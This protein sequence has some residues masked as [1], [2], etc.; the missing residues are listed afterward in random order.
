MHPSFQK[1][2]FLFYCCLR[3]NWFIKLSS[4]MLQCY[5][6]NHQETGCDIK[7]RLYWAYCLLRKKK[8]S[9][10]CTL[11]TNKSRSSVTV[12]WNTIH[13]TLAIVKSLSLFKTF[14]INYESGKGGCFYCCTIL[15]S[16]I[17]SYN[18]L[19]LLWHLALNVQSV[20]NE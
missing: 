15:Y 6:L 5:L 11:R 13:L 8:L 9:C 10:S 3:R 4:Q 14:H 16:S 17:N 7:S 18:V 12:A 1:K 20:L 2:C 19:L